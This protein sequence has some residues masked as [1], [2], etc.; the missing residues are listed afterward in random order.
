MTLEQYLLTCFSEECVELAQAISKAIRFG[1]D[2]QW[3]GKPTTNRTDI[4]VEFNDILAVLE[5]LEENQIL[6][7]YRDQKLID[8]KK[9]KLS[10]MLLHSADRGRV[11]AFPSNQK[12]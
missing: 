6:I 10:K 9:L 5:L 8:A 11:L 12:Q 1:L 4:K 2:D 7:A 3:P